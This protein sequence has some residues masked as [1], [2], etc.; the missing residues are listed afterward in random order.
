[1]GFLKVQILSALCQGFKT[2]VFKAPF[3]SSNY[4][5]QKIREIEGR[6]ALLCFHEF[7]TYFDI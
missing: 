6:S 1:M 3:V 7:F 5:I 4:I 2:E